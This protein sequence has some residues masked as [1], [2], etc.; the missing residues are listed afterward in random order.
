L[1]YDRR[2]L[3]RTKGLGGGRQSVCN[4]AAIWFII[5]SERTL[6]VRWFDDLHFQGADAC[7]WRPVTRGGED[8]CES[9]VISY[10]R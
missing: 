9:C 10:S 4:A 3:Q 8:L 2:P 6:T 7:S 5:V 1:P